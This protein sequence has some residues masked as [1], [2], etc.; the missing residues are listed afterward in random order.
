MGDAALVGRPPRCL[1]L[2]IPADRK[3]F[4]RVA[5]GAVILDALMEIDPQLPVIGD[6]ARADVLKA[7]VEILAVR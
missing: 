5:A 1:P 2:V 4:M 7:K 6:D 3:W